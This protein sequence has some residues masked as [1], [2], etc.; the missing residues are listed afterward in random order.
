MVKAWWFG[1]MCV[2]EVDSWCVRAMVIV[3]V[4]VRW[5]GKSLALLVVPRLEG[6]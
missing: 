3:R 6:A 4:F 5:K 1:M 2:I